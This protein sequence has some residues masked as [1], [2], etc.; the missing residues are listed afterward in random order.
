MGCICLILQIGVYPTGYIM[1]FSAFL[2]LV[3]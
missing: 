1:I 2:C 3:L